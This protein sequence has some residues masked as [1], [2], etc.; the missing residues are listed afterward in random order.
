MNTNKLPSK[1]YL[2]ECLDYNAETGVFTWKVRTRHHF[3]NDGAF[4]MWNRRYSDRECGRVKENAN[5]KSYRTI[6]LDGGSK[7]AHRLAWFI[8]NGEIDESMQIDHINGNGLDDRIENLRQVTA[9][10]N[11]KNLRMHKGNTSGFCGVRF[12]K[13][14]GKWQARIGKDNLGYFNSYEDAVSARIKG[15]IKRGYHENHGSERPL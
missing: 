11:S 5:G 12:C 7:C 2:D 15:E 3:K 6:M 1:E 10:E 13:S 4:K 9:S 8:F 14:Y